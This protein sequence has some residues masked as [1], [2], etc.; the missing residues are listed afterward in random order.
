MAD[1]DPNANTVTAS[2]VGDTSGEGKQDTPAEASGAKQAAWHE[3]Y[4]ESVRTNLAKYKDV[5]SAILGLSEAAKLVGKSVQIPADGAP[6]EVLKD[7]YGKVGRPD[8]PDAY[9]LK[10]E[11]AGGQKP[12]DEDPKQ[13]RE[14]AHEAGLRPEQAKVLYRR[15]LES[16]LSAVQKRNE[17]MAK[18]ELEQK[19]AIAAHVQQ[20]GGD[21]AAARVTI[22]KVVDRFVPESARQAYMKRTE[23]DAS[24]FV[25]LHSIGKAMSDD[26]LEGAGPGQV[27]KPQQ[28]GLTFDNS[29]EL[30]KR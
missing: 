2:L 10:V 5:D 7:F 18:A 29:P 6:A 16:G 20:T 21:L 11:L 4:P 13:F 15:L 14:A 17:A 8:K 28:K 26:T 19:A 24:L 22:Q 12:P 3:K 9:D 30:Y 1:A 27:A 23:S 25:A